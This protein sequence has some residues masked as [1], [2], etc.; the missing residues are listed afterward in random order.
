MSES[1]KQG[2]AKVQG[3]GFSG[4]FVLILSTLRGSL[5]RVPVLSEAVHPI[6]MASLAMASAFFQNSS[7]RGG[8]TTPSHLYS[9]F[10]LFT[11]LESTVAASAAVAPSK[12]FFSAP[13][14]A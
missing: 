8:M 12:I 13:V 9:V 5:V 2:L 4:R 1:N 10:Y 3:L 7:K 6:L 11:Q 14:I